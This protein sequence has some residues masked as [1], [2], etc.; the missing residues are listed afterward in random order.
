[1]EHSRSIKMDILQTIT[2]INRHIAVLNDDY[3]ALSQN[4]N[5][6]KVQVAILETKVA[7]ICW[8]FKA[9]AGAFVVIAVT[10]IWQLMV[11]RKNGK[12]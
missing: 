1:M 11:M 10:Q 6:L 8:W 9:V 2:E 7:E 4:Y 5:D 3:T 12:K